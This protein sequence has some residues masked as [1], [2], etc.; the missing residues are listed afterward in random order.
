MK[1]FIFALCMLSV[2]I[3]ATGCSTIPALAPTAV[4][5]TAIPATNTPIPSPTSIPPTATPAPT[6]TAVPT[7]TT[8]QALAIIP[9]GI[10]PWCLPTKSFLKAVDGPDG[11]AS[12]PKGAEAGTIDK[13]T[14]KIS[15]HIP[16][17]TCTL[18]LTFNQPVPSG[19]KFQVWDARP[20]EP[21][22]IYDMTTSPSNPR[23]AY[24]VMTHSYLIN[25]PKW[26]MDYT[27]VVVTSDGKEVFRAPIRVAKSLPE[28]CWDK[29]L[30][31]PITLFCPIMDS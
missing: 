3:S 11:P 9:D 31:D 20:Q 5:P 24:V 4:V 2:V 27:I 17:V 7:A 14:G 8:V 1:P 19:M 29:S 28:P 15:F 6:N 26:W 25:P 23:A 22:L 21:F 12:M 30:P 10:T 16:A 18:V 13:K